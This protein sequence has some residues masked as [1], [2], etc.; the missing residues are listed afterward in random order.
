MGIIVLLI[1]ISVTIAVTFLAVFCWNMKSGQYED[2]YTP[3]VRMLFDE[4][5]HGNTI[6][7]E[8]KKNEEKAEKPSSAIS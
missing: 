2:T 3:S 6:E 7:T 8:K 5:P 1:S 4:K